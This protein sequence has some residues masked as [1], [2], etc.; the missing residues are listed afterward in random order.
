MVPLCLCFLGGG[1]RG[2]GGRTCKRPF[3]VVELNIKTKTIKGRIF[4]SFF[5]LLDHTKKMLRVSQ[6]LPKIERGECVVSYVTHFPPK[7]AD[8]YGNK[9]LIRKW[10]KSVF[11]FFSFFDFMGTRMVQIRIAKSV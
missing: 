4:L 9:K 8:S 2:R 1:G 3:L 7:K 6:I 5:L 10:T 11:F